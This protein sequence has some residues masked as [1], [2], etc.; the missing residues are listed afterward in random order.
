MAFDGTEGSPIELEKASEW[1]KNYRFSINEGDTIAH[2]IGK[3]ALTALL[4]QEGAMGIRV[5]YAINDNNQ[6]ALVFAAADAAENDITSLVYDF[7][8]PCPDRCS[9]TNNALNS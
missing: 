2:F 4:E 8:T 7:T 3:D 5:Y 6:K 1:T 9:C